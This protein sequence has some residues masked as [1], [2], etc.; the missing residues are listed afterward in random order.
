MVDLLRHKI[1]MT[2][3]SRVE[4]ML[5]YVIT[6]ARI[7]HFRLWNMYSRTLALPRV[8]SNYFAR[9]NL[10]IDFPFVAL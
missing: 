4:D 9:S 3:D 5:K 8:F 6:N 1:V 10:C 7:R 2:F